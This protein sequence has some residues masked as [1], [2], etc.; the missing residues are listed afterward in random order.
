MQVYVALVLKKKNNLPTD[1]GDSKRCSFDLWVGKIPGGGNATLSSV[2]AWKIQ[3]T[4]ETG[5]P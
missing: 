2:L 5:R 1:S 4:E 3:W